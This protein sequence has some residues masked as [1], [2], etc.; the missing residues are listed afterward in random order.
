MVKLFCVI[1]G[2]AGSVF[3]VRVDE[4]DSVDDLKDAI[5][6]KNLATIMCD[7]KNLQLFLAKA[8]NGAWLDGA[9]VAAVTL[10]K[11]AGSAVPVLVDDHGN[12]HDFVK[13]DPLLWI[14]NDQ[15]FGANFQP[16]FQDGS[17]RRKG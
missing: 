9:G 8:A 5:K 15:H 7:A 1:V 13:M 3:S 14:K 12:R 11:A 2:E 6:G 16:D 10:E 4:G 17:T